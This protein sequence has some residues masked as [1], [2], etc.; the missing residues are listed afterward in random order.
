M[1][2]S[3]TGR[4]I[5]INDEIKDYAEKKLKKL[6]FY[7]DQILNINITLESERGKVKAEIKVSASHDTYFAKD[8][9]DTWQAALDGV[10]DKV[11]TEVKKK[12]DKLKDH[13]K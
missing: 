5:D 10:S 13:H 12:K 6:K 9:G 8:S 7:Y 4:H 3:Y 11:E 1:V 2:V